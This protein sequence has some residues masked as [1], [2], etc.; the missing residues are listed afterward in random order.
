MAVPPQ[1]KNRYSSHVKQR[2]RTHFKEVVEISTELNKTALG[3]PK[4]PKDA[5]NYLESKL[6]DI[7]QKRMLGIRIKNEDLRKDEMLNACLNTTAKEV[8]EVYE[9]RKKKDVMVRLLTRGAGKLIVG[10]V[11]RGASPIHA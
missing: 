7:K 1:P 4:T 10:N 11:S 2:L 5:Q 8:V 9:L 6:I 3:F